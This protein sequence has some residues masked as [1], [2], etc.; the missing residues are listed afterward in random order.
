MARFITS[1][2]ERRALIRQ[3]ETHALPMCVSVEKGG[4]RSDRQNRLNRQWMQDIAAQCEGYDAEGA[5]AFCKLHH[6]VPILRN[7]DAEFREKYDRVFRPLPYETKIELMKVPFDFP[8][9]RLMKVNQEHRYLN[10]VA[11]DFAER[12][13]VLTDPSAFGLD[14]L[15]RAA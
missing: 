14:A 13:V 3:I 2:F 1:E 11:M 15:L 12:G 5:R 8:V 4:K 6:G 10:A 7:E 9:T